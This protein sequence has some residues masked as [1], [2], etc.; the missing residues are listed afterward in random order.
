M[1]ML[2][3]FHSGDL[4]VAVDSERR[5]FAVVLAWENL[6]QEKAST[7]VEKV[8]GLVQE[9]RQGRTSEEENVEIKVCAVRI[10]HVFAKRVPDYY[11]L[12]GVPAMSPDF[13]NDPVRSV[14]SDVI[15]FVRK[16]LKQ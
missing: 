16:R 6:T 11:V 13:W 10:R 1:E 9:W 3:G 8:N 7:V 5:Y 15:G 2:L 12:I 4:G 14:A